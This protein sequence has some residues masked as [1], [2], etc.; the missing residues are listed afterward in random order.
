MSSM[1]SKVSCAPWQDLLL[2]SATTYSAT[3]DE[4]SPDTVVI[5]T[6]AVTASG[7]TSDN[8]EIVYQELCGNGQLTVKV[9]GLTGGYA[10]LF[11]RESSAAGARKGA[12]MTQLGSTLQR[13]IRSITNSFQTTASI[14]ASGHQWLRITRTSTHVYSYWSTNGTSWNLA[15]FTPLAMTDCVVIGMAAYSTSSGTTINATFTNISVTQSDAIPATEVAFADSTMEA[16]GGDTVQICVNLQN[17]CY[18]SPVTVDVALVTDS[19]PHLIGFEPQTLTFEEGDT[20]QCFTVVLEESDSSATYTFELTNLEG[21]NDSEIGAI[22][23]MVLEVEANEEEEEEEVFYEICGSFYKAP[24]EI[25]DSSE[26]LFFDR[27]GNLYTMAELEIPEPVESFLPPPS[28]CSCDDFNDTQVPWQSGNYFDLYFED[29]GTSVGF[30]DTIL[31]TERRRTACKVFAYLAHLIQRN[32]DPCDE[33]AP[34]SPINILIKTIDTTGMKPLGAATA[35]YEQIYHNRFGGIVDGLPYKIINNPGYGSLFEG[36]LHGEMQINFNNDFYLGDNSSV[37]GGQFDLYSVMLHEGLHILGFASLIK[38]LDGGYLRGGKS[39]S[40]YDTHLALEDDTPIVV[41]DGTDPYKW[42]L[43]PSIDVG[44]DLHAS[45]TTIPGPRMEFVSFTEMDVFPIYTGDTSSNPNTGASQGSSFSHFNGACSTP[46][47]SYLMNPFIPTS[48]RLDLIEN[49]EKRVLCDLG[50]RILD[51]ED[52][53]CSVVGT[54]DLTISCEEQEFIFDLCEGNEFSVPLSAF[55]DNDIG[56]DSMAY[57]QCVNEI[58]NIV[59]EATVIVED[60]E[61]LFTFC[62]PGVYFFIYTPV[63]DGCPQEGNPVFATFLVQTCKDACA[64]ICSE[65]PVPSDNSCNLVC[66]PHMVAYKGGALHE[67]DAGNIQCGN[68]D[69]PGWFPAT[70]TPDFFYETSIT[71]ESGAIRVI[72]FNADSS[73]ESFYTPMNLSAGKYFLSFYSMAA[74]GTTSTALFPF[75]VDATLVD[76]NII[77]QFEQC[78]GPVITIADIDFGLGDIQPLFTLEATSSANSNTSNYKRGLTCFSLEEDNAFQGLWFYPE[79]DIDTIMRYYIWVDEVEVVP[80]NFALEEFVYPEACGNSVVLGEV[81]CM[82]SGVTMHYT[83][84]ELVGESYEEIASYEVTDGAI[85]NISGNISSSTHELTVAPLVTTTYL[86][87]R[88]NISSDTLAGGLAFC[89]A[90]SAMVT[91]VVPE[92]EPENTAFTYDNSECNLEVSF[93]AVSEHEVHFWYFDTD[94]VVQSTQANPTFT[95]SAPGVYTV[96]HIAG[97]SCVAA[98]TEQ[99][100][101][102]L[103]PPGAGFDYDLTQCTGPFIVEV[104]AEDTLPGN[105]YAWL[106]DGNGSQST[107]TATHTFYTPGEHK[108]KLTVAN[109]CGQDAV[110]ITI[111]IVDCTGTE[112]CACDSTNTIG[113]EG[114]TTKVSEAIEDELLLA[115]SPA[116]TTPQEVCIAGKLQLDQHYNFF[117]STLRMLPGASIEVTTGFAL[118]IVNSFLHGCDQMWRGIEVETGGS[119]KTVAN[120]TIADAQYGVYFQSGG[121]GTI[122]ENRFL[123]NFVGI[124]QAQTNV[125]ITTHCYDNFFLGGTLKDEFTGQTAAPENLPEIEM[126]KPLA[127]IWIDRSKGFSIHKCYFEN[128]AIGVGSRRANLSLRANRFSDIVYSGAY[129]SSGGWSA[130]FPNGMDGYGVLAFGIANTISILGLGMETNS[131]ATFDNCTS[132]IDLTGY[133][134]SIT[135]NRMVDADTGIVARMVNVGGLDIHHNRIE[136]AQKGI[137][138]HESEP[139]GLVKVRNNVVSSPVDTG[140]Y[141]GIEVTQSQITQQRLVVEDNVVT[142]NGGGLGINLLNTTGASILNDSISLTNGNVSSNGI[143]LFGGSKNRVSESKVTGQDADNTGHFGIS[144]FSSAGNVY[145]CNTTD[146]TGT[147]FYFQGACVSPNKLRGNRLADHR[148]GLLMTSNGILGVQEHTE[149]EWIGSYSLYGAQHLGIPQVVIQSQFVADTTLLSEFLPPSIFPNSDWFIVDTTSTTVTACEETNCTPLQ[150]LGEDPDYK[151]IAE[152][153]IETESFTLNIL[154]QLQRYLYAGIAEATV[155]DTSILAFRDSSVYNTIG[156][157]YGI[158]TGIKDLFEA[159]SFKTQTLSENMDAILNLFEG[160]A[161]K[162]SLL[163]LYPEDTLLQNERLA[164]LDTLSRKASQNDTLSLEMLNARD[165]DSD[166]LWDENGNIA[167]TKIY[168]QNE[169]EVNAIYLTTIAKGTRGFS[170]QQLDD[171]EAIA[172]QCPLEGGNAVFRARAMLALLGASAVYDDSLNCEAVS[173]FHVPNPE[174]VA[175]AFTHQPVKVWPNPAGDVLYVRAPGEEN[176][177]AILYNSTGQPVLKTHLAK[178]EATH[179]INVQAIP[180]GLYWVQIRSEHRLIFTAKIIVAH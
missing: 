127:G 29:C 27:F 30:G 179:K 178:G 108:I 92:P 145:C 118:G 140:N 155:S 116:S 17:P 119:I 34:L 39:Y 131:T 128:S 99:E 42:I 77:N 11:V 107:A 121:G 180:V 102:V 122:D 97:D 33:E 156:Q 78:T 6:N 89:G 19:L 170:S 94:T 109:D 133:G 68:T 86:L 36:A 114:L 150:L 12:I 105:T 32:P 158:D 153:D 40:R 164:I 26:Q 45:C 8:Q 115:L 151:R 16:Q 52:C 54:H 165:L 175:A 176:A 22:G 5:S 141:V 83:W 1:A 41:R 49:G 80:D 48:E 43:N 87:I 124:Y 152:G 117:N 18:C 10:G 167:V 21:G 14:T 71:E 112:A 110:E 50:Y 160:L 44:T 38:I 120:T 98:E 163:F 67:G 166:D 35:Y 104:I 174:I 7:A 129:Q 74:K 93:N 51:M 134:G 46:E 57:F 135:L 56:A 72:G 130:A 138:I 37:P 69:I 75:S 62:S 2:G 113:A 13:Q 96:R 148:I 47:D 64:F 61:L 137:R 123:R 177:V 168:E 132:G 9:S 100:V 73:A 82:L 90:D 161:E 70:S 91:V 95:F 154:W 28:G 157:F 58:G 15:F 3:Y 162:D 173:E 111:F 84:Q 142:L 24:P 139:L 4:C 65:D 101:L 88:E 79:A 126:D 23:E 103:L 20:V 59:D 136:G 106:F 85:T 172:D 125:V 144:A 66:N 171:L 55:L 53:S 169:K 143:F 147:G 149:N 31:G 25:T 159:D 76:S 60:G 146:E 63:S 81:F